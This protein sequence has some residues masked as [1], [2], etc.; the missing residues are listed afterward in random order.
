MELEE[1][2]DETS[3]ELRLLEVTN[4]PD[5]N[6]KGAPPEQYL[7]E[8]FN[9]TLRIL[10]EFDSGRGQPV[11]RAWS[12]APGVIVIEMQ[13]AGLRDSTVRTLD[14]FDLFEKRLR[15][16]AIAPGEAADIMPA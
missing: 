15:L 16:R 7:A 8:M 4:L 5:L 9:P 12:P 10:P 1:E 11:R 6:G 3:P 13:S 14:G 2:E